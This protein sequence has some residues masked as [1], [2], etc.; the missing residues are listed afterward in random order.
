M[1]MVMVMGRSTIMVNGGAAGLCIAVSTLP[2]N[3]GTHQPQPGEKHGI[4]FRFG[5]R[6][7][8]APG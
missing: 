3:D 4:G 7:D 6:I 8:K 1:V 5:Y 2:P